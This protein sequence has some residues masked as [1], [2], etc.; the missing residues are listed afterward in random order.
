M[1]KTIIMY[2]KVRNIFLYSV[3]IGS[4]HINKDYNLIIPIIKVKYNLDKFIAENLKI[5]WI[6]WK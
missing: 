1:A 2:Q 5:I 4:T 3:F 6:Y